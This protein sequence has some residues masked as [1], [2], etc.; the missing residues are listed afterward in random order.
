M[1]TCG[2]LD[3]LICSAVNNMQAAVRILKAAFNIPDGLRA[4]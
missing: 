4:Y 3:S 2:E 1:L